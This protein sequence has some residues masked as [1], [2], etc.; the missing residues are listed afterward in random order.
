[1]EQVS[2]FRYLESWISDQGYATKDIRARTAM[3]NTLFMDKKKLMT[4]ELNCEQKKQIIKRILWNIVL[5]ST[6][7]GPWQLN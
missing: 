1:V 4:G 3:G 2:Q 6:F 7:S 5:Y